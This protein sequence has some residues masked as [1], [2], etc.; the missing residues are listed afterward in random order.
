MSQ[1][2]T[3]LYDWHRTHGA[4]IVDFNGWDM[5]VQYEKGILSEHLATRRYGGLF[6]VCH[7]G[8]FLVKGH[9]AVQFLQHV[10][11][12]NV[13]AVR[14]G[15]AQY[16]VI[17]NETGGAIDDAYLYRFKSDEYL[18][19]VNASNAQKD[20]QHLQSQAVK[21]KDLVLKDVTDSLG[22]IAFQGPQSG[23]ILDFLLE[24]D[25]L[26]E[27]MRNAL[28][29][30]SLAGVPVHI[31]R[32]G[33][34]GEPIGFEVFMPSNE[35]EKIWDL[36]Y[37]TGN[38]KGVVA[39]GL[40]AR[41]TLR[42]EA[43]M[44]LYGH[45][46]G[47]DENGD[48]MPILACPL[49]G[50]AVSFSV[51]KGDFIGRRAL[52]EQYEVVKD[53]RKGVYKPTEALRRRIRPV[54]LNDRGVLRP[55]DKLYLDGKE[56][57]IVTSGTVCPYWVFDGEKTRMQ[58]TD[59]TER[60]SIGLAL[61]DAEYRSGTDLETELR[62]RKAAVRMVRYHGRSEA[63]PFFRPIPA[64]WQ[65]EP[66][67]AEARPCEKKAVSLM[68]QAI[69]NHRWRQHSCINLIP[70]EMTPSRAVR[71]LSISD[72]SGRYAEHKK[73]RAVFDQ[74]V[75]YYQGTDFIGWVEE[76]IAEEM[77]EYLGCSQIEARVISG[78]MANTTV[79]SALVDYRN[80]PDRKVEAERIRLAM[81]NDLGKGGHLSAQPMGALRHFV[82]RDP[83]TE[84][85]A[86]INFPV[87]KD[88]PYMVDL[89]ETA[90]Q[91]DHHDPELIVFGKSMVLHREPVAEVRAMVADKP[92]KPL[93]MYDMA[94]VLGL[95]GPHFQQPFKDG[96]D[97]VTG[98][99]H[100]TYF[101]TQRGVIAA[102]FDETTMEYRLWDAIRS[103]A[104]PG[105]LSNHH[106]GTLL[107]LYLA[108][109]EMNAFKDTY[110]PQVIA[111]ARA[112]ARALADQGLKVEG[113]PSIGY[114]ETHQVL[115]N[116]GYAE[117]CRVAEQLEQNNIVCNYQALPYD[118]G[119][120]ASSGLRL[121]VAEMTRFGMKEKDF[122]EFAGLFAEAVKNTTEGIAEEVARF[123]QRFQTMEY[124]FDED[125]LQSQIEALKKEL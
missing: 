3:P 87:R 11:T 69:E 48:E 118:V 12:S 77:A 86:V 61:I 105:H 125:L 46:Y 36:I 52:L 109:L 79:F 49:A 8:R 101:G 78:Q 2:Q 44:P 26:P 15:Q 51:R 56:V 123:R 43:G 66:V 74:E 102:D 73:L 9:D 7:M 117:G 122:A 54:A 5:P 6:D 53:L 57:G 14:T 22:M 34:T 35:A 27:P 95:V 47:L 80:R 1:K 59:S 85:Y 98:S 63:P 17:A 10:L 89:E 75:F 97:I 24:E 72:P 90:R 94:H 45:E 121:G 112:F 116:V 107:G 88:N 82:A 81:I 100:K 84:K 68:K 39:C 108:A 29:D 38:S 115:V 124:C 32:T 106:L 103:R 37:S 28:C 110:Q 111:N 114:T 25:T 31:A 50:V 41:D 70:S 119:F 104:F 20:W 40:G 55:G 91:L 16:T 13:N 23:R 21:L 4:K 67:V 120:T 19:V 83:V 71:Y 64:S 96:A 65:H 42:L 58:V 99:T 76:R 62:G 113:D 93:L 60:R 92:E 30:G 33:Y 18:L